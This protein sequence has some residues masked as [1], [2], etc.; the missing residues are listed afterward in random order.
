MGAGDIAR[1]TTQRF[2]FPSYSDTLAQTSVIQMRATRNGVLRNMRVRQGIP[3]FVDVTNI[4]Y[5]LR[6]NGAPTALQVV[7]TANAFD[8]S[9][10]ANSIAVSAG[11]LIDVTIDKAALLTGG[12]PNSIK[13][14][15]TTIEYGA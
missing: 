5:T 8:G 14:V 10:L 2:L 3:H 1:S 4:T 13:D 9:D 15:V 7:M 12:A 11:D 6:L